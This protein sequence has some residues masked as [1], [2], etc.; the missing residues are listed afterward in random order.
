MNNLFFVAITILLFMGCSK[1]EMRQPGSDTTTDALSPLTGKSLES[2]LLNSCEFTN[3][4]HAT[5][6]MIDIM[7]DPDNTLP[8]SGLAEC[9][10]GAYTRQETTDL[11]SF[12]KNM[13]ALLGNMSTQ[14]NAVKSFGSKYRIDPTANAALWHK[15]VNANLA[16]F[17]YGVAAENQTNTAATAAV[18]VFIMETIDCLALRDLV[19][20]GEEFYLSCQVTAILVAASACYGLPGI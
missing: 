3:Y 16:F 8:V 2:A 19:N 4:V 6:A 12:T 20:T 18:Q 9:N 17:K 5:N 14:T 10:Y 13:D 11:L 15:V 7:L 1:D